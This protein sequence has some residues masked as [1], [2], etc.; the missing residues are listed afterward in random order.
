VE[1]IGVFDSGVFIAYFAAVTFIAFFMGRRKKESARDYF[2]TSGKLPWYV[3]GFG[4]IASSIS[5][6]QF[7]GN[8]G[9]TYKWGMAVVNWEWGT[10]IAMFLLLL[11]F[12]SVYLNKKII[13]MPQCLEM[14]FGEG[15]RT[16]YAV[17]SIVMG[18]FIVLAGTIYTGGFLLEQIFGI[19]KRTGIW[20]MAIFAGAYTVYG[21][22][23]SV[24]WTQ[25]LQAILLL[26]SGLLITVLGI[27]KVPG[28]F[29]AIIGTG[30][31]AHLILPA[32]HPQLPWTAILVLA[33][34]V[35]IWYL[36]TNQ[37]INQSCLGARSR[38]DAKMGI[39]LGAFLIIISFSGIE[40]PGL[41]AYALNPNLPAPDMAFTFVVKQLV[42]RG[43]RGLVL[44]GLCG[45]V[46]STIEA[47]VH[48][49]SAI[50]TLDLFN[51]FRKGASDKSLI[52]TGRICSTTVLI[53]AT[54]WS[55][56]VGRFPTIFE[57][58]QNSWFFIASPI[59][60]VFLLAA[61]WKRATSKAAFL[62]LSLCFPLFALPYLLQIA[63]R[64][65]GRQINEFNLAGIVFIISLIFMAVVSLLT[66]PP[67]PQQVEGL[68]WQPSMVKLPKE[69]LAAGYPWYKNL[70]LWCFI[71][72]ATT[73]F[74]YYKFW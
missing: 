60:T 42:T 6:E 44:A 4:M 57:F 21:G 58:F 22:L 68:V 17:I 52:K 35:S 15:S 1:R 66:K 28:G 56:I 11:V 59:A 51:K 25:L 46:M 18:V 45:A 36:C 53:L 5:T 14:R 24:A 41:I 49:T 64:S 63:E 29:S 70:W 69:E 30:E 38:W 54:L 3:I 74:I 47:V 7:I 50:F 31:R 72:L 20:L 61:L 62:T 26:G 27:I 8:V 71:W 40:F 65:L 33:F 23:I 16:L 37:Q 2:V 73:A 9:F 10:F 67:R 13:T 39:I 12:S 48:S 55:P 34:P 19:D 32:D 43:L